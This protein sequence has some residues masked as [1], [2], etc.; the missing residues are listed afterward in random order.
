MKTIEVLGMELL[1]GDVIAGKRVNHEPIICMDRK[2][3]QPCNVTVLLRDKHGYK[4]QSFEFKADQT[5]TVNRPNY[6]LPKHLRP[7]PKKRV[8]PIDKA[9]NILSNF[10]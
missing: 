1:K 3:G 2:S 5:V 8:S 4:V 10:L 9:L 6:S 7:A